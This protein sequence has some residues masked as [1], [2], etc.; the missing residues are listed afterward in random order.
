VDH[1]RCW[2]VP[3]PRRETY[4]T[5][6]RINSIWSRWKRAEWLSPG[7]FSELWKFHYFHPAEVEE[8]TLIFPGAF[9]LT[10]MA[11]LATGGHNSV[12]YDAWYRRQDNKRGAYRYLKAFLQVLSSEY[13]PG[14]PEEQS[15]RNDTPKNGDDMEPGPD[16]VGGE[17][18]T[19]G[20]W[21]LKCPFHAL[22][23]DTLVEEFPDADFIC[24]HRPANQMV[25]SWAKFQ[26][27]TFTMLYDDD[28]RSDSR[29]FAKVIADGFEDQLER[30]EEERR[31]QEMQGRVSDWI[32]RV[33][34]TTPSRRCHA[35]ATL[36]SRHHLSHPTHAATRVFVL[37]SGGSILR[38]RLQ[39][40]CEGAEK[41]SA[42]DLRPLWL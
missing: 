15:S 3:P 11:P 40:A 25:P 37:L 39:A 23:L 16:E 12:N 35:A 18:V 29:E 30:L 41:G 17:H 21:V 20:R 14:T 1:A 10:G 36:L 13:G 2:Q 33:Y 19:N 4:L 9:L 5:D 42:S 8:E 22:W 24:T 32:S 31:R 6:S 38:R 27:L 26:A 28:S 7:Y 34:A